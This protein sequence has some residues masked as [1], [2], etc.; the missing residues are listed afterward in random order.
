M[1]ANSTRQTIVQLL[2]NMSDGA[3]NLS[4]LGRGRNCMAIPGEGAGRQKTHE[5]LPPRPSPLP[6]GE[7]EQVAR[8][9]VFH[10]K[11]FL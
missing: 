3:L 5:R 7:R 2:S 6:E 11:A 8:D 4:P 9:A 10:C 1:T